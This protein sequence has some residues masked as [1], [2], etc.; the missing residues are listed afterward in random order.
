M[1][2]CYIKTPWVSLI[3]VPKG[4]TLPDKPEIITCPVALVAGFLTIPL[5]RA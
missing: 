5:R 1:L 2:S 4:T 3:C